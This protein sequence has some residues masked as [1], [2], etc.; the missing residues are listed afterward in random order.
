[1]VKLRILLSCIHK[2]SV[3]P[4]PEQGNIIVTF[5]SSSFCMRFSQTELHENHDDLLLLLLPLTLAYTDG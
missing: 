5:L 1:M 2:Y 4:L 3:Q